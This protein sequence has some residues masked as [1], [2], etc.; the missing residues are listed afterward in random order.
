[1]LS[2]E[3]TQGREHTARTIRT[4][5]TGAGLAHQG[6]HDLDGE[7]YEVFEATRDKDTDADL[8]GLRNPFGNADNELD[9]IFYCLYNGVRSGGRRYVENRSLRL[10]FT[11]RLRNV[12]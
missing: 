8:V 9:F 3:R 10:G 2:F 5:K 12:S 6:I 4:N 11:H 1:M 7:T